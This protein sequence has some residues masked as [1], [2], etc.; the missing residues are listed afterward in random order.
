MVNGT[1]IVSTPPS[2]PVLADPRVHPTYSVASVEGSILGAAFVIL[3]PKVLSDFRELVPVV[4]GLTILLVLIVGARSP[5]RGVDRR[6]CFGT[7][8]QPRRRA[9]ATVFVEGWGAERG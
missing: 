4:Y 5:P 3:V 7:C 8:L 2:A 6:G 9:R 1:S